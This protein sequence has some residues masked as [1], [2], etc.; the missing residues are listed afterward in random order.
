MGQK[1]TLVGITVT[2]AGLFAAPMASAQTPTCEVV[3]PLLQG[4]EHRVAGSTAPLDQLL[5]SS[6]NRLGYGVNARSSLNP[7]LLA[8]IEAGNRRMDGARLI[9]NSIRDSFKNADKM[10]SSVT[11]KIGQIYPATYGPGY[12]GRLPALHQ[13]ISSLS[14]EGNKTYSYDL[15]RSIIARKYLAAM[16]VQ[17]YNVGE[18]LGDFWFNHLNISDQKVRAPDYEIQLR[19]RVCG[20]FTELLLASARHAAMSS[21]LDND[22]NRVGAINENYG[23]EII[24]LHTLGTGPVEVDQNGNQIKIYEQSEIFESARILTGWRSSNTSGFFF[25]FSR[26][27]RG[28]KRFP[29]LFGTPVEFAQASSAQMAEDAGVRFIRRLVAHPRTKRNICRKLALHLT[30]RGLTPDMLRACVDAYGAEG[31]LPAVY[32]SL[33]MHP[34]FWNAENQ[35]KGFK[36]PFEMLISANRA[37]GAVQV[38]ELTANPASFRSFIERQAF[39]GLAL[40]GQPIYRIGPP[41]GYDIGISY[42]NTPVT[43]NQQMNQILNVF[44]T[45]SVVYNTSPQPLRGIALERHI[46]SLAQSNPQHAYNLVTRVIAPVMTASDRANESAVIV[47][48]LQGRRADRAPASLGSE[49]MPVR[50]I[51]TQLVSSATFMKK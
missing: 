40:M 37:L 24:E 15:K 46:N 38:D 28:I 29:K 47:Q 25:D 36:T 17:D 12:E 35:Q 43:L 49:P 42:W 31:N 44:Q 32:A 7:D 45:T 41:T 27:D 6:M 4:L 3:L 50:S 1:R 11:E 26:H 34:D 10:S 30:G 2:M 22:V 5:V 39:G 51:L 33:I 13:H 21:Y 8:R 9:A 20:K 16:T 48:M 19:R 18:V 23:R 14:V